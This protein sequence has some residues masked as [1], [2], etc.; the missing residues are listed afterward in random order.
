MIVFDI[1]VGMRTEPI[2]NM[3]NG[4]PFTDVPTWMSLRLVLV[5]ILRK[6]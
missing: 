1:P 5:Q 6:R 2:K 3:C 4:L